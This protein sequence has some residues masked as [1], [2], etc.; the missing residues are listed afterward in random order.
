MLTYKEA[1]EKS[2]LNAVEVAKKIGLSKSAYSQKENYERNFKDHE[3][4]KFCDTVG[5]S[6]GDLK[7][8][9]YNY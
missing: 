7:I 2:K 5:C 6:F 9:G 4:A 1:R 8:K 3:L